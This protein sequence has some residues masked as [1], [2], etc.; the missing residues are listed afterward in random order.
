MSAT[1]KKLTNA[2]LYFVMITSSF[3]SHSS[4]LN[5]EGCDALTIK[6]INVIM[7]EAKPQYVKN[8]FNH[9]RCIPISFKD[10]DIPT[11]NR[12][13]FGNSQALFD[14]YQNFVQ[15]HET[16]ITQVRTSNHNIINFLKV[17]IKSTEFQRF[18]INVNK[19]K[20]L[21]KNIKTGFFFMS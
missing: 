2:L 14:V 8:P 3:F 19:T 9:Q 21:K 15:S 16:Q 12:S 1:F 18:M 7:N 13:H 6:S 20:I 17:N 10:N 11:L 5:G 4:I